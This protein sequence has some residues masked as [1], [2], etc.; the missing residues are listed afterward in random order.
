MNNCLAIYNLSEIC[1]YLLFVEMYL[2][3]PNILFPKTPG[4]WDFIFVGSYLILKW[5]PIW[6]S[7]RVHSSSGVQTRGRLSLSTLQ[8]SFKSAQVLIGLRWSNSTLSASPTFAVNLS[9]GNDIARSSYIIPNL[10]S[11]DPDVLRIAM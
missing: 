2:L 6:D 8:F 9:G 7:W 4:G 10:A 3:L 5:V 1:W 11:V